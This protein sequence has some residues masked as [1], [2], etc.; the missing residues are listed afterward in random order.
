MCTSSQA[1]RTCPVLATVLL[2]S[3]HQL[4][5]KDLLAL[6]ELLTPAYTAMNFAALC[7]DEP[8]WKAVQPIGRRG[9]AINYAEHVKDEIVGVLS[10]G[11][12][13]TVLRSAAD[14][15][16]AEARWQLQIRIKAAN[17]NME[18]AR[19]RM[20]C[21]EYAS[22]FIEAFIVEH[23]DRHSEFLEHLSRLSVGQQR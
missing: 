7:A 16:R 5:A 14:Q 8:S 10:Y 1:K 19:F 6:S 15:A 23:D 11:D 20:W 3:S 17:P 4:A 12:A 2:L 21:A 22:S 13:L 18:N 9:T